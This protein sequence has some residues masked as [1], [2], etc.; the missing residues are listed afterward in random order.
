VRHQTA[1]YIQRF[2]SIYIPLFPV[3]WNHCGHVPSHIF[4]TFASQVVLFRGSR[5]AHQSGPDDSFP[6]PKYT[7][8]SINSATDA[9]TDSESGL[10]NRVVWYG[11]VW[12][13]YGVCAVRACDHC[14]DEDEPKLRISISIEPQI[15]NDDHRAQRPIDA[16]A[17]NVGYQCTLSQKY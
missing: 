10:Q 15:P 1:S 7:S 9:D 8:I 17:W 2:A 11:M 13:G 3:N 4:I 14:R 6:S 12:Y 5:R 16:T